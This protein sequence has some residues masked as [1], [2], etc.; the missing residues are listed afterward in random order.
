MDQLCRYA[1]S[2]LST[3]ELVLQKL[4]EVYYKRA[5]DLFGGGG[6]VLTLVYGDDCT[7]NKVIQDP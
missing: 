2:L 3:L 4:K 5:Q 7:T 6:N 1:K